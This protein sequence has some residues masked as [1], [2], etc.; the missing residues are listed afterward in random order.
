MIA[1][2]RKDVATA[3][4]AGL[5]T[6]H[7]VAVAVTA[8]API[9]ELA[10]PVEIFGTDR[11]DLADPWYQLVI[12]APGAETRIS[13]NFVATETGTMDDLA[14]ADTVIIPACRS[15]HEQPPAPLVEALR[16]AHGRGARIAGI[17]SGAFVLAA[18]GLLEGR[19]AATPWMHAEELAT[20]YPGVQ[21]DAEVIY[22]EDDGIFTS[23]GTAAGIDL[24]LELV[25]RDLGSAVANQLARRLVVPPHREGN[26]AQF[27]RLPEVRC[28]DR[29]VAPLMD[30][31]RAHLH[32]EITLDDLA[33][34]SFLSRRTL[35]RRFASVV[36]TSPVRWLQGERIRRAQELLESTT[37]PIELVATASGFG[38][39][40]NLRQQFGERVGV[41]PQ[42][43][44]R[45][46]QHLAAI[47]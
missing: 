40:A 27:V 6:P 30:W 32:E 31:A 2:M 44:R 29:T 16:A 1:H 35:A 34:Q 45:N 19:R 20:R 3:S 12:C 14:A 5:T 24:C 36:G 28:D 41:S 43:F 37:L 23:A 39:A 21:V 38:T 25:R 9:F 13:G 8:G 26:Q 47:G 33:R 42:Q 18:A 46:F 10:V 11:P 17:C 22:L 7:R 15:V 4:G